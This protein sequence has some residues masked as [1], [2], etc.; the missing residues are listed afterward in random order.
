ME[1][2]G[3]TENHIQLLYSNIVSTELNT[4]ITM[5][6]KQN[7]LAFIEVMRPPHAAI[8]VSGLAPVART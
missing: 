3:N 6:S 8:P 7:R 2:C 4:E 1:E 5:R